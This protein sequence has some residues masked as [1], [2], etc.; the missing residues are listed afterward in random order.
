M[1]NYCFCGNYIDTETLLNLP[2]YADVSVKNLTKAFQL[3][4]YFSLLWIP[5]VGWGMIG[6]G[7]KKLVVA[8]L[9]LVIGSFT[10]PVKCFIKN[11]S[12]VV[13]ILS[14]ETVFDIAEATAFLRQ[15][16][17]NGKSL[18]KVNNNCNIILIFAEG[19]SYKNIRPDIMPKTWELMQKSFCVDNYFCH[20]QPTYRG[21]RGQ[22][23]S[24]YQLNGVAMGNRLAANPKLS[25]IPSLHKILQKYG[26][27]T[28]FFS[29]EVPGDKFN[30]M[31]SKMGFDDVLEVEGIKEIISDK[32]TYER[33]FQKITDCETSSTK[34]LLCAYIQGTH[35]YCDSPHKKYGD[36]SD[37]VL[38]KFYNQDYWFGEFVKKLEARGYL[39]NTLLVLTADH[40]TYPAPDY[41]KAFNSTHKMF[42]DRIPLLF[43]KSGIVP[44]HFDAN[45]RNSLALTPTILNIL[46]IENERNYFLGNSLFVEQVTPYSRLSI[47]ERY[48]AD[49]SIGEPIMV[50]RPSI[51]LLNML[52]KYYNL[53]G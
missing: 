38:N 32:E 5:N 30:F 12:E 24:G 2:C 6:K 47:R 42:V 9:L 4:V 51:K 16:I 25:E 26:Y 28:F 48:I 22:L 20:T 19:T 50:K 40:S 33:I 37:A 10:E 49:T 18:V 44:Q 34:Y 29:P 35:V 43:Y 15:S 45:N 41:D 46:G 13:T 1:V 11:I 7:Y 3:F 52:S 17:P 31:L 14:S 39:E 21:I 36:G 8:M 53:F 27:K 23:I